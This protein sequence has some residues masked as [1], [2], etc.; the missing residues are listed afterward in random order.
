LIGAVSLQ[1]ATPNFNNTAYT[2]DQMTT[3][4]ETVYSN[5][6]LNDIVNYYNNTCI[7]S[8][9]PGL[10]NTSTNTSDTDYQG[11]CQILT[12]DW[13]QIF[14]PYVCNIWFCNNQGSC[15]YTNNSDNTSVS[16]TCNCNSGWQGQNCQFS[17]SDYSTNIQWATGLG[18][19]AYNEML[20]LN[21]TN[22]TEFLR[23]LNLLFEVLLFTSNSN[24]ADANTVSTAVYNIEN[25]ALSFNVNWN[26]PNVILYINEFLNDYYNYITMDSG[27]DVVG[28]LSVT[29]TGSGTST[30][31]YGYVSSTTSGNSGVT[32]TTGSRLRYLGFL[33]ELRR[34]LG[35]STVLTFNP[36]PPQV[37]IPQNYIQALQ[38]VDNGRNISLALTYQK[39]PAQYLYQN[40]PNIITQIVNVR[41]TDATNSSMVLNLNGTSGPTFKIYARVANLAAKNQISGN[42]SQSCQAYQY[43]TATKKWQNSTCTVDPAS[44]SGTCI[45]NCYTLATYG[46]QCN[47]KNN[48]S[49]SSG[50]NVI[51]NI[52]MILLGLFVLI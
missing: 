40:S 11:W 50:S 18:N 24:F 45:I 29:G 31:T 22:T 27:F 34:N 9:V 36:T 51:I 14:A 13:S 16:V 28:F 4:W 21:S 52:F 17:N 26:D 19:F 5:T 10:F 8:R 47:M 49:N 3:L 46:C 39:N 25:A 7:D 23:S 37:V 6:V 35:A 38:N 43:N 12:Y 32:L 15:S 2:W 41:A 1:T 44:D 20:V 30:S 48:P 33:K 42:P